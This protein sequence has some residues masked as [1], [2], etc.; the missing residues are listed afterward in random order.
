V[1]KHTT[2][3]IDPSL[4]LFLSPLE[5]S[6]FCKHAPPRS[7]RS[8]PPLEL[9]LVR[10]GGAEQPPSICIPAVEFFFSGVEP[11]SCHRR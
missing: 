10:D 5:T 1:E 9:L 11:Y 8:R 2:A 6:E 4:S 3:A 7:R